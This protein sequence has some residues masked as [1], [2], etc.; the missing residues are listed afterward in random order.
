LV[1]L[2]ASLI[3]AESLPSLIDRALD[4]QETER[5]LYSEDIEMGHQWARMCL[6]FSDS[7]GFG[8]FIF[9]CTC[10]ATMSCHPDH[11]PMASIT[12]HQYDPGRRGGGALDPAR[13]PS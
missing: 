8:T 6:S 1:C 2:S 4:D 3:I 11:E 10:V 5:I 12:D 9:R 13:E 7:F